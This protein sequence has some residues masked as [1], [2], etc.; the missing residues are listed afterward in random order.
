M[1]RISYGN[2][3]PDQAVTAFM[4]SL[5]YRPRAGRTTRVGSRRRISR[6]ASDRGALIER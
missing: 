1:A 3:F 5:H 4:A 6:L 2:L